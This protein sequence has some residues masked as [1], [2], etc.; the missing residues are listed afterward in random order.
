MCVRFCRLLV[1]YHWANLNIGPDDG[2]RVKVKRSRVIK[3][4]PNGT[5]N[6][7]THGNL[8]SGY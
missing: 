5:M 4:H 7:C 1:I 2:T 3:I 8:P 6:V